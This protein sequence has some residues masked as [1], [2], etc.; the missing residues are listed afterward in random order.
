MT[1][2]A[3]ALAKWLGMIALVHAFWAF[4][5]IWP[6]RSA[7]QLARTVVGTRGI[8]TMPSTAAC[9]AAAGAIGVAALWPL[10]LVGRLSAPWPP[11]LT[12]LIGAGLAAVFLGRGVAAYLPAWRA[13]FPETPFATLDRALYAP[14]CIAVAMGYLVLLWKG[15]AP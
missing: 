14:F 10:L 3:F 6:A 1:L 5:G 9:A 12:T 11:A 15:P 7:E 13:H 8:T 2:I 4:G